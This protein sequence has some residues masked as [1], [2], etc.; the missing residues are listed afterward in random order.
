MCG[1]F[2]TVTAYDCDILRSELD[3]SKKLKIASV[4]KLERTIVGLQSIRILKLKFVVV[5]TAFC[6]RC[7]IQRSMT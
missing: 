4:V 6:C 2:V 3:H 1:P 7:A 5:S